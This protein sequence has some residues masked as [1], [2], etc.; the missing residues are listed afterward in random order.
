MKL[1][2]SKMGAQA[3]RLPERRRREKIFAADAAQAER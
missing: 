3:A 2:A 1:G